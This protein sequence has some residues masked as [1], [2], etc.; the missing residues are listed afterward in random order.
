MLSLE[1]GGWLLGRQKQ[2]CPLRSHY[3]HG[4]S[5]R[6][7]RLQHVA[8]WLAR[9]SG[10]SAKVWFMYVAPW[11]PQQQPEF[12]SLQSALG[13]AWPGVLEASEDST[14]ISLWSHFLPSLENH[15]PSSAMRREGGGQPGRSEAAAEQVNLSL[16]HQVPSGADGSRTFKLASHGGWDST[17]VSGKRHR[18][19]GS[20]GPWW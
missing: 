7:L 11:P 17:G 10:P 1:A 3:P 14:H 20:R 19:I 16:N 13:L 8:H 6:A 4:S 15:S 12:P 5:V 18:W 9:G 2:A